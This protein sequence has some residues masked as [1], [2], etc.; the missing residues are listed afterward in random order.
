M[1]LWML[2]AVFPLIPLDWE[3]ALGFTFL[4]N[5]CEVKGG[6]QGIPCP[7]QMYEALG[8]MVWEKREFVPHLVSNLVKQSWIWPRGW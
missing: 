8:V 4:I 5:I 7:E 6:V 2:V 3:D 1:A